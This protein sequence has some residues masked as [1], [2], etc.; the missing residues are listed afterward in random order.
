MIND[1]KVSVLIYNL[2]KEAAIASHVVG[3]NISEDDANEMFELMKNF[4]SI[5]PSMWMDKKNNRDLE[6][7][8][9]CGVVIKNCEKQGIDASYTRTISTVLEYQYKNKKIQK[10]NLKVT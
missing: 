8:D 2:M 9:I 1:E 3:V 7:D 4:E 5:I 10:N 6:L